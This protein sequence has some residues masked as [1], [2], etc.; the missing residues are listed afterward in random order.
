MLQRCSSTCPV[1]P[2]QNSRDSPVFRSAQHSAALGLIKPTLL[3]VHTLDMTLQPGLQP[4]SQHT[5][6]QKQKLR[7]SPHFHSISFQRHSSRNKLHAHPDPLEIQEGSLLIA[8]PIKDNAVF[9]LCVQR[10]RK[11]PSTSVTLE[12]SWELD[13]QHHKRAGEKLVGDMSHYSSEAVQHTHWGLWST[14]GL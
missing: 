3:P 8:Q 10:H 12:R 1:H 6:I 5:H 9:F 4:A 13:E 2:G 11:V 14:L 7:I